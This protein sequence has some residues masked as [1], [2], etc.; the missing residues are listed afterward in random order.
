MNAVL[1]A[2]KNRR[3]IRSFK[4][5]QIKDHELRA[6]LEA[7]RYAPN[8]GSQAWQFIA[9]Q[10]QQLIDDLSRASKD[11]AKNHEIPFLRELANNPDFHAFYRAPAVIL[12]CAPDS[13]WA[14]Y[15]CA[16][17]TENI[18]LAAESLGLA[19][20]WIYFGLLAFGGADGAKYAEP[21]GIRQGYR[22]YCSVALGNRRGPIPDPAPRKHDTVTYI[23]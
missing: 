8:A 11:A 5:E 9:V 4:S 20:C 18:L 14:P 7:A 3:S 12:V 19:A 22:P 21:L 17:A 10:R 16:A 1:S 13:P 6:I 15:D 23:K 2:I